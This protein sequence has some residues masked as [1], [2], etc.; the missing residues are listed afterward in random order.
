MSDLTP[1]RRCSLGQACTICDLR[2]HLFPHSS[3]FQMAYDISKRCSAH[4]SSVPESS[5][6]PAWAPG[7][8][9]MGVRSHPWQQLHACIVL[10]TLYHKPPKAASAMWHWAVAAKWQCFTARA[11]ADYNRPACQ[12]L[13]LWPM[14]SRHTWQSLLKMSLILATGLVCC[15]VLWKA[16]CCL[17]LH[18]ML[19]CPKVAGFGLGSRAGCWAAGEA[20]LRPL[21]LAL[22][23]AGALMSSKTFA[24]CTSSQVSRCLLPCQRGHPR[25]SCNQ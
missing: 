24:T 4:Q 20:L 18:V 23:A 13:V 8:F 3:L 9:R 16:W 6:S 14:I 19:S 21:L 1:Q 22:P 2:P 10:L 25:T 12:D 17:D 7:G 5:K 11:E 15:M